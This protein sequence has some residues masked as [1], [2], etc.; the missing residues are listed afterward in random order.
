MAKINFSIMTK[1]A[2]ARGARS[3]VAASYQQ[4]QHRLNARNKAKHIGALYT[5][6]QA[7][8]CGEIK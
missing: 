5:S 3:A 1:A 7:A 2:A 4:K 6:H 8:A